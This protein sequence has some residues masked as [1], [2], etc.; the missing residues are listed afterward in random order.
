MDAAESDPDAFVH[1]S[2]LPRREYGRKYLTKGE[3]VEFDL[4]V[5]NGKPQAINVK[6]AATDTSTDG[7]SDGR[8]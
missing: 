8:D 3:L 2:Q 6:I 5:R 4:S 7:G 1:H